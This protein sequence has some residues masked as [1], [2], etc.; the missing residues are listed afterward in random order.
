MSVADSILD[1]A[2]EL[3]EGLNDWLGQPVSKYAIFDT[4]EDENTLLS[5]NG[6]LSTAFEIDGTISLMGQAEFERAIHALQSMLAA[7][8]ASDETAHTVQVVFEYD[9]EKSQRWLDDY[10]Y[11]TIESMRLRGYDIRELMEDWKSA[12]A[13]MVAIEKVWFILWTHPEALPRVTRASA[14]KKR[15]KAAINSPRGKNGQ[16]WPQSVRFDGLQHVHNGFVSGMRDALAS[17][18]L[19]ASLKSARELIKD[20]RASVAPNFTSRQWTPRLPGDKLTL[21]APDLGEGKRD[22]S[23]V[24]YPSLRKQVFPREGEIVTRS[25]YRIGPYYHMPQVM[26]LSPED[27]KPFATL[28]RAMLRRRSPWR[29]SMTLRPDGVGAFYMKGMLALTFSFASENNRRI[30]A[31]L[32]QL[33]DYQESGGHVLRFQATFDTWVKREQG[34]SEDDALARLEAQGADMVS[35]VQGW[36]TADVEE[37]AGAPELGFVASL[38]GATYRSPAPISAAPLEDIGIMLPVTRPTM[39]WKTGSMLFRSPDGKPIP[40]ALGSSAQAAWVEIGA[41]QQGAGKSVMLSSLNWAFVTQPGLNVIPYL[42]CIDFGTSGLGL[43]EVLQQLA[44]ADQRHL[45]IYKRM[46]MTPDFAVNP[47]DTPVCVEKPLAK[48]R[49]ALINLLGLIATPD[50]KDTPPEG[51]S[52]LA[53]TLIDAAYDSLNPERRGARRYQ[54]TVD[55]K[56]DELIAEIGFEVDDHTSWWEVTHAL[57]DEGRPEAALLAQRYAMPLIKDLAQLCNDENITSLYREKTV[58]GEPLTVYMRRRLQ[59]ALGSYPI[60]AYPTRFDVGNA[61]VISLDLDEVAP[62]GGRAADRQSSVMFMIARHLL[63]SRFFETDDDLPYIPERARAFHAQRIRNLREV[64]K[65]WV[66]D[67]GH[68]MVRAEASAQQIVSDMETATRESRKLV[69]Q[70]GFYSQS[71]GDVPEIIRRLATTVFMMNAGD[72]AEIRLVKDTWAPTES[73]LNRLRNIQPPDARGAD[74]IGLFKTKRGFV[75]Q[76]LT[77][78]MGKL[79]L[80]SFK[81]DAEDREIRIRLFKRV[82]VMPALRAMTRC[83]P[84][85]LKAEVERRRS[86]YSDDQLEERVADIMGDLL[87]ELVAKAHEYEQEEAA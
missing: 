45:Y 61:R 79:L 49:Q 13:S 31:A 87:E 46:K 82:A 47:F 33:K 15:N 67:E 4:T 29:M 71:I 74:F 83:Y 38:P 30:R 50:D 26:T 18:N 60:L 25:T 21:R 36:G 40:Y 27:P 1:F 3:S 86:T 59:E 5:R 66:I 56:I 14:G 55:P 42:S 80:A 53:G 44:P 68:R 24:Q 51:A 58:D 85:G 28:Y 65:R 73:V 48:H 16:P 37:V 6:T 35:A 32:K 69:L 64:P 10:F 34:E 75:Q 84:G 43:I 22:F 12:M 63:M 76:A 39:P 78:T 7:R 72:E 77:S 57:M 81:S 11:P 62:K 19:I 8:L 2:L 23:A 17:A 20:M 9:P 54:R 41:G 52:G 70:I